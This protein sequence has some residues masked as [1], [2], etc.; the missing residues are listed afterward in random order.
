MELE[1]SGRDEWSVYLRNKG[2]KMTIQIDYHR[3]WVSFIPSH[4]IKYDVYK[5]S[6]AAYSTVNYRHAC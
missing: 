6:N 4:G 1:E 5:I 2:D 3:K